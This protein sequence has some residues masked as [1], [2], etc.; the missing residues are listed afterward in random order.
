MVTKY[1]YKS[2]LAIVHVG[3]PFMAHNFIYTRKE[4]TIMLGHDL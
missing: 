3:A 4:V 1:T 2:N